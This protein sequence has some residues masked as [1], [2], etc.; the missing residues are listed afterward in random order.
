MAEYLKFNIL[1]LRLQN[2][3][4]VLSLVIKVRDL[5]SIHMLTM[6][7]KAHDKITI[8]LPLLTDLSSRYGVQ[9]IQ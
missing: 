5:S 7:F 3:G 8:P 9:R 2:V 4:H 6:V 1:D